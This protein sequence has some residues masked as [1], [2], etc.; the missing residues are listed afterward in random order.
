MIA[1]RQQAVLTEMAA[2]DVSA[3]LGGDAPVWLK[4]GAACDLFLNRAPAPEE[5]DAL[6]L[7]WP[8]EGFVRLR[9]PATAVFDGTWGGR[10]GRL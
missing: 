1:A 5:I 4:P 10:D 3:R 8:G 6:R 7:A 2:L 9:G